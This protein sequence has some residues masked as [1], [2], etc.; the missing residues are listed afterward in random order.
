MFSLW[1]QQKACLFRVDSRVDAVFLLSSVLKRLTLVNNKLAHFF[2]RYIYAS[3]H[4]YIHMLMRHFASFPHIYAA[5]ICLFLNNTNR[6]ELIQ[7]FQ[8]FQPINWTNSCFQLHFWWI[9]FVANNDWSICGQ[10]HHA[11]EFH[12]DCWR[13]CVE[14]TTKNTSHKKYHLSWIFSYFHPY[15][16]KWRFCLCAHAL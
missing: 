6:T 14:S 11:I 5:F 2:S 16:T 3:I 12:R 4:M 15:Q 8:L 1:N 10:P 7:I 13:K 9:L